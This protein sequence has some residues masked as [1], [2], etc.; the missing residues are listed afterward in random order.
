MRDVSFPVYEH[1]VSV[2]GFHSL[3]PSSSFLRHHGGKKTLM[4]LVI[5][6]PCIRLKIIGLDPSLQ[7]KGSEE[8]SNRSKRKNCTCLSGHVWNKKHKKSQC[9]DRR[10]ALLQCNSD[11]W[12]VSPRSI[13]DYY[14]RRFDHSHDR[15]GCSIVFPHCFTA[16]YNKLFA[17]GDVSKVSP[18]K[19][20][21]SQH[22]SSMDT[23]WCRIKTR[24]GYNS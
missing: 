22:A 13:P 2:G 21:D 24:N 17:S 20:T 18:I 12:K 7:K 19:P 14:V 8:E 6:H 4:L 10:Q 16:Q 5:L 15:P 11:L 9:M 23:L 3:W 1:C